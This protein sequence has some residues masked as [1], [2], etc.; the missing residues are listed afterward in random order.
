MEQSP[1]KRMREK[2][3]IERI[4][5]LVELALSIRIPKEPIHVSI[6]RAAP[7]LMRKYRTRTSRQDH[8]LTLHRVLG[9]TRARLSMLLNTEQWPEPYEYRFNTTQS[10]EE[11][12][13]AFRARVQHFINHF[14]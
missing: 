9:L 8:T 13:Q 1:F 12:A 14:Q 11:Q 7:T 3:Q 10:D 4:H 2:A 6:F 5:E